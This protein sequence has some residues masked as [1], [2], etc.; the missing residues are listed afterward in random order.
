MRSP[1]LLFDLRTNLKR[2]TPA[3]IVTDSSPPAGVRPMR[4]GLV[5]DDE[6]VTKVDELADVPMRLLK[7]VEEELAKERND[8]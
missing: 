5:W 8:A 1:I 4:E 7:E 2:R 3:L 6:E